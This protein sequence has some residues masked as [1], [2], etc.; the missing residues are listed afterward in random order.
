MFDKLSSYRR[1][2]DSQ[3]RL[4]T[5]IDKTQDSHEIDAILYVLGQLEGH[6]VNPASNKAAA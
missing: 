6:V 4:L 3:G 2:T 1:A 5:E